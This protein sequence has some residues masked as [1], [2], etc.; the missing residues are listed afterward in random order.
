[1]PPKA[2]VHVSRRLQIFAHI[3]QPTSDELELVSVGAC[4]IMQGA[5][6]SQKPHALRTHDGRRFFCDDAFILR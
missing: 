1:M 6:G 4:S 2:G 3:K 5:L